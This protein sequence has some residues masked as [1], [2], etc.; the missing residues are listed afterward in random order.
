ML[1][2]FAVILHTIQTSVKRAHEDSTQTQ[3]QTQTVQSDDLANRWLSRT[4]SSPASSTSSGLF[5]FIVFAE[6][7]KKKKKEKSE[8]VVISV[9]NSPAKGG[10]YPI[11]VPSCGGGH[12]GYG[13]R[14][15]R[16]LAYI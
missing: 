1:V 2:W 14:R 10:M 5:N 6:A 11:F 9:Q 3:T 12:G 7:G 4:H 16:S 8:V 13:R 15:K